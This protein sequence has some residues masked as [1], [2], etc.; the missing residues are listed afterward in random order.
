MMERIDHASPRSRARI[1]GVVY[2]FFFLTA[3]LGAVVT[4]GT[5]KSILAHESSF[6]LGYALTLISTA[7]YVAL[8]ALLYQLFKPVS[9]TIAVMAVLFS[10]MGS[11]LA[12]VQSLF[13]LAPLAVLGSGPHSSTFTLDQSKALAQMLLDLSTQAGSV[14]VVFFGVFNLLIGYLISRST[15]LPRILGAL[16]AL[17]GLGWLTFL[18]PPLANRLTFIDVLGFLAE[19][20]LMLWLLAFGVNGKRWNEQADVRLAGN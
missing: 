20:L 4:P 2:L 12:A 1:T 13:Q 14:A 6:R 10:L 18:A 17:S 7:S 15:F 8:A 19:A 3:V 16:M 11:A 5:A 9:R